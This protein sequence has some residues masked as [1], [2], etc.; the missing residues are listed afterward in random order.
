[1]GVATSPRVSFNS[2]VDIATS[3]ARQPSPPAVLHSPELDAV[4]IPASAA[5]YFEI[6]TPNRMNLEWSRR[7]IGWQTKPVKGLPIDKCKSIKEIQLPALFFQHPIAAMSLWNVME[8]FYALDRIVC[9]SCSDSVGKISNWES[10]P[11]FEYLDAN[12]VKKRW[13]K[14]LS[15]LKE[16]IRKESRVNLAVMSQVASPS[17]SKSVKS[18]FKSASKQSPDEAKIETLRQRIDGIFSGIAKLEDAQ[19]E[20]RRNFEQ[21]LEGVKWVPQMIEMIEAAARR[22]FSWIE[23]LKDDS[24]QEDYRDSSTDDKRCTY[25]P[26][27]NEPMLPEMDDTWQIRPISRR[28]SFKKNRT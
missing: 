21:N 8:T 7:I 1:M 14:S 24:V 16:E 18:R 4:S 10:M 17:D 23:S 9:S 12:V 11:P 13:N 27:R 3:L 5:E 28:D 6:N 26:S 15:A 22:R 2:Y 20:L 19:A 25:G